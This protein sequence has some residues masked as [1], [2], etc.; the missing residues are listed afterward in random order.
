[1]NSIV[2]LVET[3]SRNTTYETVSEPD[4]ESSGLIHCQRYVAKIRGP[5]LPELADVLGDCLHNFRSALDH[6]VWFASTFPAGDLPDKANVVGFPVA[7]TETLYNEK[8]LQGV[9]PSVR[10]FVETLQPY[11]SG[12]DARS[13]PLW[14]LSELD[15]IDKHREVH[16]VHFAAVASEIGIVSLQPGSWFEA[17]ESGPVEDGTVLAR[18]YTPVSVIKNEVAVNLKFS[19]GVAI[20]ETETTPQLP[21]LATLADIRNAVRSACYGMVNA[22]TTDF[23]LHPDDPSGA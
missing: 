18:V 11:H 3:W 21:L 4:P 2:D 12:D 8:G 15:R 19:H 17:G 5:E 22:L 6:T 16:T 20:M 1:L 14:V 7:L 9:T 10:A 23:G 13:H